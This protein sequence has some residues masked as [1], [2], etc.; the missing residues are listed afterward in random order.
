MQGRI[1]FG[2]RAQQATPDASMQL[3]QRKV[4]GSSLGAWVA[5]GC[6]EHRTPGAGWCAHCLCCSGW[7]AAEL[8]R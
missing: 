3:L 5:L 4:G 7:R 2:G 8:H 6:P 1:V